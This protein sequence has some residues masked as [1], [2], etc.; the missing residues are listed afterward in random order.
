MIS[1]IN[2]KRSI[3]TL[4][5]AAILS[6]A[7]L[8]GFA[9]I[10]NN[11]HADTSD[12]AYVENGARAYAIITADTSFNGREEMK[13]G[14]EAAAEKAGAY[15]TILAN[16]TDNSTLSEAFDALSAYDGFA[17]AVDAYNGLVDKYGKDDFYKV[18]VPEKYTYG[19]GDK[20]TDIT[21][22]VAGRALG[23]IKALAAGWESASEYDYDIKYTI[24]YSDL[25]GAKHDVFTIYSSFV[26]DALII[27]AED[28]DFI[29]N[30]ASNGVVDIVFKMGATI[31]F[32][33]NSTVGEQIYNVQASLKKETKTQVNGSYSVYDVSLKKA[34]LNGEDIT[35]SF[36]VVKAEG[37]VSVMTVGELVS[38][39]EEFFNAPVRSEVRDTHDEYAALIS[40]KIN[41]I[42][43]AARDKFADAEK[44]YDLTL[45][46]AENAAAVQ[47]IFTAAKAAVSSAAKYG[48]IPSF[49]EETDKAK[50]VKNIPDTFTEVDY[51]DII[52]NDKVYTD[53]ENAK[54]VLAIADYDGYNAAV[55]AA[56]ASAAAIIKA[57]LV[58]TAV[59][60]VR[61][62]AEEKVSSGNYSPNQIREITGESQKALN[63][64]EKAGYD[65]AAIAAARAA[66]D[67]FIN[68]TV[69]GYQTNAAG[70]LSDGNVTVTVEDGKLDSRAALS[71][72]TS[73]VDKETDEIEEGKKADAAARKLSAIEAF[74]INVTVV[75]AAALTESDGTTKYN[76]SVKLTDETLEK[77]KGKDVDLSSFLVAY[78][79]AN[80][81]IETYETTLEFV[82][83]DGSTVTYEGKSVE[84]DKIAE[85]HI[86]FTTMH[87][88]TYYLMGN[89][90]NL[91]LSRLTGLLAG[92]AESETLKYLLIGLAALVGVILLF[93]IIAYFC[94]IGTVYKIK[95]K[96][97]GGKKVRSIHRKYGRK[98]PELKPSEKEGYVF[99]GWYIDKTLKYE[100]N[101]LVMPRANTVLYAKWCEP[102]A[103]EPV[104]ETA[105][106]N[107]A[108]LVAYYDRL[109]AKLASYKKEIA[110]G[111]KSYVEKV[112][113]AK[114]FAENEEIK[115][116]VR[117]ELDYI[118]DKD[119]KAYVVPEEEKFEEV[120]VTDDASFDAAVGAIE[121]MANVNGL[122]RNEEN[123]ALEPSTYE[124]IKNVY[125][126]SVNYSEVATYAERYSALRAYASSYTVADEEKAEAGKLVFEL[127]PGENE[128][129]ALG[130]AF[131]TDKYSDILTEKEGGELNN[132]YCVT[133]GENMFV[134]LEL[135]SRVMEENG[136]AIAETTETETTAYDV[137][138]T[139][140]YRIAA[141][142]LTLAE[143]FRQFRLY[144]TSFALYADG[145]VD[146]SADGKVVVKAQLLEDKVEATLDPDGNAEDI[147]F[148]CN[149]CFAAAK[150]KVAAMLGGYGF[151]YAEAAEERE[152]VEA[153]RFCYKIKFPEPLTAKELLGKVRNLVKGY[154]MF[155]DEN[156][157][158]DRTHEGVVVVKAV[159]TEE[160]VK[161][162][163]DPD[164][165]AQEFVVKAE[166]DLPAVEEAVAVTMAKY[167]L[168]PDPDYVPSD[169]ELEGDSFGY[170]I[171][172]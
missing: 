29:E 70:K 168:E 79:D 99:G 107:E 11:A 46:T 45:Y 41:T 54:A 143:M 40:N 104:A 151:E 144:V 116:Q 101:R 96:T 169:E 59:Y 33:N 31:T 21:A 48:D 15:H 61:K 127:V 140:Q 146:R 30:R 97:N 160:E 121:K 152:L 82:M 69:S 87:F 50:A 47:N 83:K 14:L 38:E 162:T 118:K 94:S 34:D 129:L 44:D 161:V 17:T 65:V 131:C 23:D 3:I 142:E 155:A 52:F 1:D 88:S 149:E 163:V 153:D 76:V 7:L 75:G 108:A 113:L 36:S 4:A 106:G 81:R 126:Y 89:T 12:L 137:A 68:T 63:A 16:Y 71:A 18:A 22:E 150:E 124:D 37:D 28:V 170:R 8:F 58:N 158:P 10:A 57:N 19:N 117:T 6:A 43:S 141:E 25:Y 100:F 157:E 139:Y 133:E 120:S 122:V 114:L 138:E 147:S 20:N 64:I 159:T 26:G 112:V 84:W 130:F 5:L 111:E 13:Q 35:H 145:E 90:S 66:F 135:V 53:A 132:V 62:T 92:F 109:R 93:I 86:M 49:K 77:I 42:K 115:L 9:P 119:G 136:L 51:A 110:E 2:K 85:G 78:F 166:E 172:F 102:A 105:G 80:G 32:N 123:V 165:E 125:E 98:L 128:T 95:F 27:S 167:G 74:E 55:Q 73:V 148:S 171:K 156:A 154:A 24:V 103:E 91:A 56:L 72:S 134:A 164:A 67:N 39:A 60:D